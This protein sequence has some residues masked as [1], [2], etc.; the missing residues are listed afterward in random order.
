MHLKNTFV[1]LFSQHETILNQDPLPIEEA[2][3][4]TAIQEFEWSLKRVILAIQ[5]ENFP[6]EDMSQ[7]L[8]KV[9]QNAAVLLKA[10]NHKSGE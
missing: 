8:N 1:Q 4:I 5:R 7:S 10:E 2:S 6:D 3:K 9:L